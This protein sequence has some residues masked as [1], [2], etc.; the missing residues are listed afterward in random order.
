MVDI[1]DQTN[2]FSFELRMETIL[3]LMIF[4]V[5][6]CHLSSCERKANFVTRVPSFQSP[7]AGERRQ[8]EDPGNE[9][10][11]RPERDSKFHECDRRKIAKL[12]FRAFARL[13]AFQIFQGGRS[14]FIHS[15]DKTK[16]VILYEAPWSLRFRKR[17]PLHGQRTCLARMRASC[18]RSMRGVSSLTL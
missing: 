5:L 11:E 2:E 14:T 8:G 3:M 6:L 10:E 12:T 1:C 7:G 15:L 16:T 4:A 17:F 18:M 9:V 13:P